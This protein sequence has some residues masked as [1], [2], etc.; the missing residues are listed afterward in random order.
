MQ[1]PTPLGWHKPTSPVTHAQIAS[2]AAAI[3]NAPTVTAAVGTSPFLARR[4]LEAPI[5]QPQPSYNLELNPRAAPALA[6]V[7]VASIPNYDAPEI[8]HAKARARMI[9]GAPPAL[10][11]PYTEVL[12]AGQWDALAATVGN[13]TAKFQGAVA[14][15]LGMGAPPAV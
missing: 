9:V 11:N 6:N 14:S 5:A 10:P 8:A 12:S 15:T 2:L 3:Q 13:Y 7:P 4:G 1:L